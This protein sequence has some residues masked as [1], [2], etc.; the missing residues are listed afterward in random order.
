MRSHAP[1]CAVGQRLPSERDL[2]QKFRV[3]RTT[4]REAMIALE[5]DGLVEVRTGSDVYVPHKSPPEGAQID[6]KR[7]RFA[8]A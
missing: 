6:A 7:K 4:I 8:G 5:L 2:A 1:C 3:S